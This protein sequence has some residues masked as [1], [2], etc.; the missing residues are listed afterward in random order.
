LEADLSVLQGDDARAFLRD[1][2][3][4]PVPTPVPAS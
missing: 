3:G 2:T 4:E 1:F